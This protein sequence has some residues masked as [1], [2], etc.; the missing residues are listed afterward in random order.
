MY[1]IQDKIIFKGI[2]L[3]HAMSNLV[4]RKKRNDKNSKFVFLKTLSF[5]YVLL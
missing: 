1:V 4:A 2:S 5:Q 3:M